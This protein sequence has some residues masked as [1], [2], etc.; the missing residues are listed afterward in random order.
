M[1]TRP[2]SP[3]KLK[4]KTKNNKPAPRTRTKA[5]RS[6]TQTSGKARKQETVFR[7]LAENLPTLCWIANADGYIY[8][9]NSRWYEYTGTSFKDMQ[10]WGWQSVH[11]P[12]FLPFVLDRWKH[13]I[14]T[15]EA[16]EMVF[17][18]RGADGAFRPFLTRVA[19]FHD[20]NGKIVKWFG[21]NTD[22]TA[23]RR[24]EEHLRLLINELNHRVKNTLGVVQS[25]AAL[26]F[27]KFDDVETARR[28]FDS[29][30]LALSAAH[31][32]L[33]SETWRGASIRQIAEQALSPFGAKNADGPFRLVGPDIWLRPRVVVS[34]S[35]AMHELGTNAMKYGALSTESGSIT[36][37]W[38][39][40]CK[41][42]GEVVHI[43]WVE[44]H[45]PPVRPPTRSGFGTRLITEG[46]KSDLRGTVRLTF[47]TTGLECR[48]EIPIQDLPDTLSALEYEAEAR[49]SDILGDHE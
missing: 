34:L 8:W 43:D 17:P 32:L 14:A 18:L 6:K 10:G 49:A 37:S 35:M 16:F 1:R 41:P 42:G 22:I 15:G 24:Y 30:L 19:P 2:S 45:G 7:A 21:M 5:K 3:R 40:E 48:M 26:T 44:Q 39:R 27:K 36:L 20:K 47:P 9:Y 38:S 31:N 12:K 4:R 33:T 29:R 13:S 46:F 28:T 25:L 23:Q 11:H